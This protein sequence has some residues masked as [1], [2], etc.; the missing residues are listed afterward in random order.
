MQATDECLHAVAVD[1]IAV[2]TQERQFLV[3][4][5]VERGQL[6]FVAIKLL[7]CRVLRE[8][9]GSQLVAVAVQI[10]QRRVLRHVE[11]RELI[12]GANQFRQRR[13][14]REVERSQLVAEAVQRCQGCEVL[15][16]L[17]VADVLHRGTHLRDGGNLR[18]GEVSAL[19]EV[20]GGVA[21]KGA[22]VRVG[23]V[24]RI[25]MYGEDAGIVFKLFGLKVILHHFPALCLGGSHVCRR[26]FV[27]VI[28]QIFSKYI[29]G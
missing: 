11:L 25:N 5:H 3:L 13:V 15:Y 22:E 16:A 20:D 29:Q 7:Q 4:C 17:Q 12:A 24:R 27:V 21:D 18:F 8:V 14:L 10:G 26:Y 6:V 28:G 23:E 19:V 2:A 1:L 9:E